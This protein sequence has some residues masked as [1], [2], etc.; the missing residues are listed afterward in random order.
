MVLPADER[1]NTSWFWA[2]KRRMGQ[3]YPWDQRGFR[4]KQTTG[5]F[6]G[7]SSSDI[8]TNTPNQAHTHTHYTHTTKQITCWGQTPEEHHKPML[9]CLCAFISWWTQLTSPSTWIHMS[10]LSTPVS[11]AT[12]LMANETAVASKAG[13][14]RQ[15]TGWVNKPREPLKQLGDLSVL[16]RS[17]TGGQEVMDE[18][19]LLFG[20]EDMHFP[21]VC[22]LWLHRHNYSKMHRK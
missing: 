19:L 17:N 6:V 15:S 5:S 21:I 10:P 8:H 3:E 12:V 4:G 20:Q 7:C 11:W 2:L 18:Q 16:M 13:R 9:G 1:L 14:D 22:A